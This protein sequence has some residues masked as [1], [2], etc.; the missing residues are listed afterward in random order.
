MHSDFPQKKETFF[1]LKKTEVLKVQKI[2]VKKSQLF[3]LFRLSQNKTRNN[4]W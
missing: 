3:G 2:L 1:D 4:A